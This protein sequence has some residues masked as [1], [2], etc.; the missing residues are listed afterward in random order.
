MHRLLRWLVPAVVGALVG[1]G[2][3]VVGS[4][5]PLLTGSIVLSYAVL[6]RLAVAHPDIVYEEGSRSWTVG[7]WSG[8]STGFILLVAFLGLSTTLPIESGLRL[9]IQILLFGSGWAMWALGVAYAR[10]KAGV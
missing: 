6:A 9:S 1:A 7:R 5:A 8:L 4:T 10:A 3:Y 2:S